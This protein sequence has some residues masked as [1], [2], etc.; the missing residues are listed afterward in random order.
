MA[1]PDKNWQ[2]D[3]APL[4]IVGTHLSVAVATLQTPVV[5]ALADKALVQAVGG[6]VRF[7]LDG[8]TNPTASSGFQLRNGD[9]PVIINLTP[10]EAGAIGIKAIGED[11][12]AVLELQWGR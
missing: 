10:G 3:L 1:A 12:A 4:R 7:T 5:P 11:G 8:A 6:N 2:V 9:A